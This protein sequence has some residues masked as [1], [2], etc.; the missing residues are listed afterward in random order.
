MMD[1]L[2][3]TVAKLAENI[4]TGRVKVTKACFCCDVYLPEV[5]KN[6]KGIPVCD[7]CFKEMHTVCCVCNQ[8]EGRKE[9]E[10][11]DVC[12]VCEEPVCEKHYEV[13]NRC[14][15][16]FC[17]NHFRDYGYVDLCNECGDKEYGPGE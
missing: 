11:S 13:C 8:E 17:L 15:K 5:N 14:E 2:E 7:T 1:E 3:K 12:S 9:E 16:T 10:C 6:E 4:A